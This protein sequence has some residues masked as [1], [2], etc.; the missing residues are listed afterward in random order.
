MWVGS[1]FIENNWHSSLYVFKAF[2][3][4]YTYCELLA[5]VVQLTSVFSSIYNEKEKEEK[6]D[7]N[8][9]HDENS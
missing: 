3:M 2:S 8:I 6:K 7:E 1:S 9:S 5:T 4:I